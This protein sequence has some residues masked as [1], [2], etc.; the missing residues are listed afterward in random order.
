MIIKFACVF[1]LPILI[2]SHSYCQIGY[3]IA[4]HCQSQTVRLVATSFNRSHEKSRDFGMGFV[5]NGKYLAT[6][7]HLIS[8]EDTSFKFSNIYLTYNE[9]FVH[10]K[11]FYDSMF[12]I[13]KFKVKKNQYDF[14]KHRYNRNDFT[15]DF[16]I[17][18]LPKGLPTV[19]HIFYSNPPKFLDTVYSIG[20]HITGRFVNPTIKAG[21]FIFNYTMSDKLNPIYFAFATDYTF[22]FS[23]SPLFNSKGEICGMIQYSIENTPTKILEKLLSDGKITPMIYNGVKQSYSQGEKL[24][25]AI[26]IKYIKERYLKGYL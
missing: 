16:V 6:C 1:L 26:D 21:L 20:N 10:G 24:Q 13:S 23:G 14:C 22:G 18:K 15:T 7:Y 25:F 3:E 5:L 4:M 9:H 12:L 2:T 11:F 19:K 8:P 17:L